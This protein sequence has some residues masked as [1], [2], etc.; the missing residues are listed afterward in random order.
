MAAISK[1]ICHISP[2]FHVHILGVYVQIL[3]DMKFLWAMLSLGQLYTDD[4]TNNDDNDNDD[5]DN[6]ITNDATNDTWHTDY[7]CIGSVACML[8]NS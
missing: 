4:N 8:K 2:I 1:C 7:D 5:N 3:Q 6:D